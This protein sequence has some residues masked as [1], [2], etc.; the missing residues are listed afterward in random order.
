MK[1]TLSLVMCAVLLALSFGVGVSAEESNYIEYFDDGSYAI[2]EITE[3]NSLARATKTG[4]AS[5]SY[6]NSSGK[7]LVTL[8]LTGTFNYVYGSSA[9]A[10]SATVAITLHTSDAKYVSRNSYC[11]GATAHGSVTFTYNGTNRTMST[12]LTCDK[13]GNLS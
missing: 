1:R 11:S 5:K 12:K 4:V 6:Y 10:T 3:S 8:E 13:Y 7:K 9:S 2:T